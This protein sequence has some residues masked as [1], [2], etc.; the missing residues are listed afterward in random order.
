MPSN[1][2]PRFLRKT[3]TTNLNS[4]RILRGDP[5]C[6]V[7]GGCDEGIRRFSQEEACQCR[8]HEGC[9]QDLRNGNP[10]LGQ[11]VHCFYFQLADVS[12]EEDFEA[13]EA[14]AEEAE[15]TPMTKS[16][17]ISSK[18]ASKRHKFVCGTPM[19][20]EFCCLPKGHLG[21]CL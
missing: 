8:V 20:A 6:I 4:K 1:N 21:N 17:P 19:G 16:P 12:S 5:L 13:G 10:R 3:M 14:E 11:C 18:N 2:V 9:M 7:C 15:E